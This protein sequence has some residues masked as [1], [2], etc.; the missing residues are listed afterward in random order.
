LA[1][2]LRKRT[3]LYA[4]YTQLRNDRN[5]TY[6]LGVG[7]TN[8]TGTGAGATFAGADIKSLGL[9]LRHTF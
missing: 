5:A 3:Q 6:D 2:N 7:S 4:Q 9:G 8:V 1:N